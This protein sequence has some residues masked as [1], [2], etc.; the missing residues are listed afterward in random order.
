M[1]VEEIIGKLKEIAG[2][3]NPELASVLGEILDDKANASIWG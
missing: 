2:V 1:N 3:K